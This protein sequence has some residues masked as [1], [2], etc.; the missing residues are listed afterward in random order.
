MQFLPVIAPGGGGGV[1]VTLPLDDITATAT[2]AFGLRKLRSAYAG[3]CIKVR[4]S[5]DDTTQD[6]GFSG[7][8]LDVASLETFCSGTNGF[9]DTWYDQS[10]NGNN[11]TQSTTG[12][13]PQIVSSGS[14]LRVGLRRKPTITYTNASSQYLIADDIGA[15]LAA[16]TAASVFAIAR[17]T[18]DVND[19]VLWSAHDAAGNNRLI[20]FGNSSAQVRYFIVNTDSVQSGSEVRTQLNAYITTSDGNDHELFQG[21]KSLDSA[22]TAA[23]WADI[24]QFSIGQE[25]DAGVASGFYDGHIPELIVFDSVISAADRKTLA[26]NSSNHFGSVLASRIMGIGGVGTTSAKYR[27]QTSAIG[28]TLKL[29]YSTSSTLNGS[30]TSTGV[31]TIS[32]DDRTGGEEITGLAADTTYYYTPVVDDAQVYSSDYPSFKT[33]PAGTGD[34]KVCF[35]SCTETNTA[36]ADTEIWDSII[37]ESPDLFFHLGDRHYGDTTVLATQ[38][39]HYKNQYGTRGIDTNCSFTEDLVPVAW[40]VTGKQIW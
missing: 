26:E 34:I 17:L 6:I 37:A 21:I 35:G 38:R 7:N 20:L 27:A 5:S 23:T 16:G 36:G 19:R 22:T 25:W 40:I 9:I 30:I 1:S 13:Q 32:G 2:G 10:T 31:T 11:A 3:N 4:R 33:V 29:R 24:T 8:D 28:S 18:N 39:T 12:N 15:A 14:V